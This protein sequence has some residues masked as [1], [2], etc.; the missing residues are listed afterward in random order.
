[1]ASTRRRRAGASRSRAK[2][3]DAQARETQAAQQKAAR[4]KISLRAY[5]L[6]RGLGWSLVTLGIV[7]GVSHMLTHIQLWGFAS[8]GI[9]D[10][11]AGYPMAGLLGIS[12]AI[13]LTR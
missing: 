3:R 11:V 8:Q 13:V 9:M 1:M 6:R 5:R 7:V 2:R 10:L 12:G 4:R